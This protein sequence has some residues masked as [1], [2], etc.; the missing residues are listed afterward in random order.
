MEDERVLGG[1]ALSVLDEPCD[2]CDFAVPGAGEGEGGLPVLGASAGGRVKALRL[3]GA[4]SF[5]CFDHGARI[6][7]DTQS[8]RTA[9]SLPLHGFRRISAVRGRKGLGWAS[10]C[11]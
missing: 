11:V 5:T 6:V 8:F 2:P 1:N 4:T 3:E 9:R 10:D 7:G